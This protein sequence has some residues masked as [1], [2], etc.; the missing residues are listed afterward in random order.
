MN[1]N[2]ISFLTPYWS[3][4]E[5][6]RMHLESI[7]K[8]YPMAPILVS[9]RGGEREEMEA[10]RSEFG[11]RYW[12]EDCEFPSAYVRLLQRCE[13]EHVCI[14]DH[15]AILLAT[16]DPYL[17]GLSDGR[18][19]LVGVEERIRVPDEIWT[20]HW[21]Q[22]GG[23]LRF[24]PGC[25][26]SNVL[27]FNL[28]DFKAKWG[29]RGI[30]GSRTGAGHSFEFCYGICQR[31]A[32]HFYLRPHHLK[33][34][35]MGN[36]LMDGTTPIVW[37]QWFGSYRT[38]LAGA[39]PED[40]SAGE[41]DDRAIYP[42]AEEG[43]IAFLKDYPQL[44]L[45]EMTPAWGPDLDIQAE[46]RAIENSASPASPRRLSGMLATLRRWRRYGVREFTA[47]A[48]AKLDLWW[49]LR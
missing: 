25:M 26:D 48:W 34:Y 21:P 3:G 28:K 37:H 2:S 12:L 19:D 35:G 40:Q 43:E 44:D 18:Y 15:D 14:L 41:P 32:R 46:R 13:T 42:V 33:K 16:L 31:L 23:W 4:R 39:A 17:A 5:M 11:I 38:R 9:K 7:R 27:M 49:R 30:F 47:R 36:L 20:R 1:G 8:F 6:M 24:A 22:A 45:S 10:Y 29:L